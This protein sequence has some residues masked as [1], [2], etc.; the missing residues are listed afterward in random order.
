MNIRNTLF[1]YYLLFSACANQTTEGLPNSINGKVIGVKDGDTIEILFNGKPLK[2]RLAH[3]DCPELRKSQPF[4]KLA[5][6]FA[7]EMCY[8]QMVNILN[9]NK[10]DRYKRLIGV[11]IN[12]KGQNVNQELIKAGL[13]WHYKKYSTD[14]IYTQLEEEARSNHI[15]LWAEKNPIPP[16]EWRKN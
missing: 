13:A 7:S 9:Q 4:G 8:G 1:L 3:I 11:V 12:E 14:E 15:G 2:I 5:K 16:W 10:F 6:Q